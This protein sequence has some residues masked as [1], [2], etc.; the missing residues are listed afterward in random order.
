[1][2]LFS[3]AH[4]QRHVFISRLNLDIALIAGALMTPFALHAQVVGGTIS[5]SV[6]DSGG[7][8]VPNA[9]IIVRN[10]NTGSERRLVTGPS[11]AF[12]APSITVGSYSIT[13]HAEG[14]ADFQQGGLSLT[15]G[16]SLQLRIP[17][18]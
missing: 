9:Q 13:V 18:T 12:S 7:A 2:K 16:Q 15:V 10:E 4:S 5:G 17:S 1:M 14:F 11:G 6:V 3:L 8:V